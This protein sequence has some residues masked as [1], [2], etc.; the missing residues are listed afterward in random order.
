MITTGDGRFQLGFSG[1]TPLK[2]A[3]EGSGHDISRDFGNGDRD[4]AF[5]LWETQEIDSGT[6]AFNW[7]HAAPRSQRSLLRVH[8]NARSGCRTALSGGLACCTNAQI[9]LASSPSAS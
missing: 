4:W 7:F 5:Q 6:D 8:A 3:N 9:Q 2:T 1:M